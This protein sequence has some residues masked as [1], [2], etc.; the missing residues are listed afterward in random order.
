MNPESSQKEESHTRT[1]I[2]FRESVVFMG[3]RANRERS[4]VRWGGRGPSKS[5]N[6]GR[7]EGHQPRSTDRLSL[8]PFLWTVLRNFSQ[9]GQKAE[10]P[11]PACYFF[12]NRGAPWFRFCCRSLSGGA[13]CR[14]RWNRTGVCEAVRVFPKVQNLRMF[15]ESRKPPSPPVH[16]D[17]AEKKVAVSAQHGYE[18]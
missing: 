1:S 8:I 9:S 16:R 5:R 18:R 15:F 11:P 6:E 13:G 3:K 17:A 10:T 4:R 7:D 14:W 2:L 12:L